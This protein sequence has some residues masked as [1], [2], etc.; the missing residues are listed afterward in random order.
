MARFIENPDEAEIYGFELEDGEMQM[1]I[2]EYYIKE[3]EE[4]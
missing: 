3:P 4:R 2:L 1:A